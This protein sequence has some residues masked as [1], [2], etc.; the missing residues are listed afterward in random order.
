MSGSPGKRFLGNTDLTRPASVVGLRA[1]VERHLAQGPPR[2]MPADG[3][4]GIVELCDAHETTMTAALDNPDLNQAAVDRLVDEQEDRTLAAIAKLEEAAI[5]AAARELDTEQGAILHSFQPQG[6]P[7]VMTSGDADKL[8]LERLKAQERLMTGRLYIE[9]AEAS[10]SPAQLEDVVEDALLFNDVRVSRLVLAIARRKLQAL[11]AAI[12][13]HQQRPNHPLSFAAH[14]AVQRESQFNAAHPSP[15]R[16]LKDIAEA[17]R[18]RATGLT[19]TF[20]FVTKLIFGEQHAEK[21]ARRKELAELHA[22][23]TA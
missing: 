16:R 11:E 15:S 5:A 21:V 18:H 2:T 1:K 20:A 6:L 13:K 12:P 7:M 19:S 22:K 10:D 3:M 14:Q 4:A 8:I 9:M 23:H 17:R